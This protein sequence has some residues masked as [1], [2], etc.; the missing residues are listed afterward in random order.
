MKD[1]EL[2]KLIGTLKF[3]TEYV[4]HDFYSIESCIELIKKNKHFHYYYDVDEFG[5]F[6][7]HNNPTVI[8]TNKNNNEYIEIKDTDEKN[9]IKN[10]GEIYYEYDDEDDEEEEDNEK[11]NDADTDEDNNDDNNDDKD[12]KIK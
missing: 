10:S 1:D 12:N 8:K 4:T 6:Y 3:F 9:N 5:H 7:L 2:I 11:D